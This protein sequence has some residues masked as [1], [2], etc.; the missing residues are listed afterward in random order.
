[1]LQNEPVFRKLGPD[2]LD[3]VLHVERLSFSRDL[4]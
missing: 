1:M 3:E 4:L 2:D